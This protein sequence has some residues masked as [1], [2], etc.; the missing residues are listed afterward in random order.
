MSSFLSFLFLSFMTWKSKLMHQ[1]LLDLSIIVLLNLLFNLFQLS[2][3]DVLVY[4]GFVGQS[5]MLNNLNVLNKS[6]L[7]FTHGNKL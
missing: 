7:N 6:Y 4:C 1:S 5:S 3:N 2:G